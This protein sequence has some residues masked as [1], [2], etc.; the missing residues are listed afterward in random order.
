MLALTGKANFRNMSRYCNLS[1]KTIS[2]N[3][4]KAA[5]FVELNKDAIL[6]EYTDSNIL[7]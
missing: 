5:D 7:L 6:M 1:E 3:F 2:R 4:R